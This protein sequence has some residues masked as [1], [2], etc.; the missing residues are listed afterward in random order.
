MYNLIGFLILVI[1]NLHSS[2]IY[3]TY[4]NHAYTFLIIIL[5]ISKMFTI[6]KKTKKIIHQQKCL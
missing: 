2:E 3:S 5:K 4:L 1:I 6:Y